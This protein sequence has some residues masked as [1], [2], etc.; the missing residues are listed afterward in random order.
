[1]IRFFLTLITALFM[2]IPASFAGDW[3]KIKF[4]TEGA[5]PPWNGTNS[6]GE[7][8]GGRA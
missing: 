1:M 3:S 6:A 5:Y 2:F 8:E 7:L 4:G